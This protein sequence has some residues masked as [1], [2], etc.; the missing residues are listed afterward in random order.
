MPKPRTK[1]QAIRDERKRKRRE[2]AF[3]AEE[4]SHATKRQRVEEEEAD[5]AKDPDATFEDGYEQRGPGGAPPAEREFF[6]MLSDEEQ[7]YFRSVDEQLDIDDFPS[8]EERGLYLAGV[9]TEAQGKELKL[10]CSQSCS[11]LMERLI[12]MSNTRQKK[13]LFEQFAG[14]FLNLIQHRFASHCCETLFLQSA[15]IVTRELGGERDDLPDDTEEKPLPYMEELFLLTLDELEGRLGFLLT[16]KFASHTLRVLLIILSGRPLEQSSMKSLI[17]SKKKEQITAPWTTNTLSELSSQ[18]RPVPASFTLAA[19]KIIDDSTKG[20]SS[21]ELR[22]LA[23]HP[24]GNPVLQLFLE[25]DIALSSEFEGESGEM[26]L[27]WR[28][29]PGAP[30]TL[31]DATTEASDFVNSMLYDAIGSRL[32][33]V[34]ITHCPGKVFKA[35]WKH[36]FADRIHSLLRN[37]IASYPAIRVLNRLSKEDL[38]D[39]V[40][41]TL[42]EI[43]KLISLSRFNVVKTLFERCQVR[44]VSAEIDTLTK[45]LLD[46]YG[47]DAKSLIPKLCLL[48][49]GE[50]EEEK[51]PEP[52]AKNR[53]ALVSHGSHLATTLLAIPGS[54]RRA[55][56]T[57]LSSLPEELLIQLATASAPTSHVLADALSTPSHDK[58]FHKTL[59]A[60]LRPHAFELAKSEHGSRVLSAVIATPS[61]GDGISLPFHFKETIMEQLGQHEQELRESFEGRRV[62]RNWKGDLWRNRR[63]EWVSWAKEIDSAPDPA[64]AASGQKQP[65]GQQQPRAQQQP[66]GQEPS[67]Q[68]L[69]GRQ[70][71]GQ[72]QHTVHPPR[73]HQSRAPRGFQSGANAI[74]VGDNDRK[75]KRAIEGAA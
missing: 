25:L 17:H 58:I 29:L 13:K 27:L 23:T 30:A 66:R 24:T 55:I 12:L 60:A 2:K 14:H 68:Q 47:S 21:T 16:D 9:F 38:V 65:R 34:L 37:D 74:K 67:G 15:P 59:V 1:R 8:Q 48:E 64:A 52:F 10:A 57:S 28:L 44:Q 62:W 53:S 51:K 26:T 70:P 3:A 41:K 22:V 4:A 56:Q 31:K 46:A 75:R 45:A 11:R 42:P 36:V 6:G 39:A 43:P 7:E 35:L 32:L 20:M 69:R 63:S 54:P 18:L 61:R 33:E 5:T 71:R 72:Q 50:S 73:R 19:K 40:K 49:S